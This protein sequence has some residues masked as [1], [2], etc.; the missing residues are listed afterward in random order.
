MYNIIRAVTIV[1]NALRNVVVSLVKP[2]EAI[3]N[4]VSKIKKHKNITRRFS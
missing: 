4:I 2:A 3:L 1:F